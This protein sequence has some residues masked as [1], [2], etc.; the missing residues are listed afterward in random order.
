MQ[1]VIDTCSRWLLASLLTPDPL[2]VMENTPRQASSRLVLII[3]ELLKKVAPRKVQEI[4]VVNGPGSFTGVR[5]GVATARNLCQ[6]WNIKARLVD[7][8]QAYACSIPGD[9]LVLI[10]GKQNKYYGRFFLNDQP[11][12]LLD[13]EWAKYSECLPADLPVY[14]D[15]PGEL[16]RMN[17]RSLPAPDPLAIA[18]MATDPVP[19]QEVLPVYLRKDPATARYPEGYRHG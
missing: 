19:W 2:T 18:R 8:L 16:S 5:I 4:I 9:K 12:N 6:L 11:G 10:D 14:A 1:L 3:A 13:Q 7:S 17:V 15:E